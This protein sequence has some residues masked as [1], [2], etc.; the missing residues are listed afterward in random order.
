M[1]AA[2]RTLS[3]FLEPKT[4]IA[5]PQSFIMELIKKFEGL[6]FSLSVHHLNLWRGA[7]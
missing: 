4:N 7:G 2:L 6:I 5:S 1:F 3:A